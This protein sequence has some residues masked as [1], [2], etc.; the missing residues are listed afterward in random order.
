[1]N[2]DF[3]DL[4]K[5]VQE[6]ARISASAETNI[7]DGGGQA[8]KETNTSLLNCMEINDLVLQ[9]EK[10]CGQAC[11]ELEEELNTIKNNKDGNQK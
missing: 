1:M 7:T 10:V 2:K 9:L 4:A 8:N 11:K 5:K 3:E 6:C